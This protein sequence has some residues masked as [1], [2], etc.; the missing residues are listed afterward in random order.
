MSKGNTDIVK[1]LLQSGASVSSQ[2]GSQPNAIHRATLLTGTSQ[3]ARS[4]ESYPG[5]QVMVSVLGSADACNGDLDQLCTVQSDTFKFQVCNGSA[6]HIAIMLNKSHALKALLTAGASPLVVAERV[7]VT[8]AGYSHVFLKKSALDIANTESMGLRLHRSLLG[9]ALQQQ[10]QKQQQQQQQQQKKQQQQ[11]SAVLHVS[12]DSLE[13]HTAE[14]AVPSVQT[15][16]ASAADRGGGGGGKGGGASPSPLEL[17]ELSE[18]KSDRLLTFIHQYPLCAEA[19][20]LLARDLHVGHTILVPE[21]RT[22]FEVG[23]IELA[24][25][26]I[27]L[28]DT[29]AGAFRILGACCADS[30]LMCME[31]M[32][33]ECGRA[34]QNELFMEVAYIT[35]G[36]RLN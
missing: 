4:Q 7:E 30:S 34:T 29:S 26:A 22:D 23:S 14:A 24:K 27:S 1:L 11:P 33:F 31:D 28:D 20:V 13:G 18:M 15:S 5:E 35:S 19:Y 2:H 32:P 3:T 36:V 8:R 25:H 9:N 6:L 17:A 12:D 10:Q 21:M 16:C